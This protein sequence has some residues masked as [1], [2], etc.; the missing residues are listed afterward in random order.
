MRNFSSQSE[1]EPV[2]RLVKRFSFWRTGAGFWNYWALIREYCFGCRR[3]R[4]STIVQNWLSSYVFWKLSSSCLMP[5]VFGWMFVVGGDYDTRIKVLPGFL[6]G[7][8]TIPHGLAPPPIFLLWHLLHWSPERGF[9]KSLLEG[10]V[11]CLLGGRR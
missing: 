3:N 9:G 2:Y 11:R 8:I 10:H 6:L 7:N 4:S 5:R 1:G